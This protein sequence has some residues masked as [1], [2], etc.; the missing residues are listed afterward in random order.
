MNLSRR[1]FIQQSAA[2]SALMTSGIQF[3]Q[4]QQK[5]PNVLWIFA[6]DFS[7]ELACYGN[8]LVHTPNLDRLAD[9]GVRFTRA[10]ATCP[11]C[12]PARSAIHTG[13][14]QTSI[15][16]HNHR[17]HRSDGYQLPEYI[18]FISDEFRKAGYFTANIKKITPQLE[19]TG[20]TDYNYLKNKPFDGNS[21][22]QL[23]DNQPFFAEINFP[24][25]HRSFT[26]SKEHPTDPD[27]IELPPYYP[28]HPV[29]REDFAAYYDSINLLD[30]KVGVVLRKLEEDGLAD[31]TIVIFMG[32]HGRAMPRGKQFLYEAGIRIPLIIRFP[33]R[34]NA[35]TVSDALVSSLDVTATSLYLAGI[36]VPE[37][38]QG[39]PIFDPSVP[40]RE[41]IFAARDRCD[42][43]VDRIRCV[44]SRDFKYIRNFYP[45][46]PWTQLNRYKETSY[47][48]LR[49]MRKLKEEGKLT[50]QQALFMADS[51]PPEELYDLRNDPHELNNLA[52][53][54]ASQE[55]IAH[56]RQVLLDWMIN[57]HDLGAIPEDPAIIEPWDQRARESYDKRLFKFYK[58]EG[59][60]VWWE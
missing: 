12:S 60:E 2:I 6:E 51:R 3:A 5:R 34:Q 24:E 16:A 4:A 32:D 53:Q 27:A 31:N 52:R 30:E 40:D 49:V 54:P 15:G 59:L 18:P 38:M 17:S 42:E 23:K 20:K 36:P 46:R 19:G 47:P 28:D 1:H 7:P 21:W 43:T 35:G 8:Q 14:Y 11:V 39:Q 56:F 33:D 13:M 50:P 58:N 10:Y 48:I 9:E 22:E 44:V 41:Y 45:E 57:T 37:I 55:K 25:T 29:V 26:R